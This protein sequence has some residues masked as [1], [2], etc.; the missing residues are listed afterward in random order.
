MGWAHNKTYVNEHGSLWTHFN[1][2]HLSQRLQDGRT[3]SVTRLCNGII[4]TPPDAGEVKY[5]LLDKDATLA[6]LRKLNTPTRTI[7]FLSSLKPQPP[8]F[9][10]EW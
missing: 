3:L 10:G 4:T 2:C 1:R 6:L 5:E 8:A 9:D 7:E